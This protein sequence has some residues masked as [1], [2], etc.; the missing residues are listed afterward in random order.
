MAFGTTKSNF[1][2]AAQ[3][4]FGGF[5][6]QSSLDGDNEPSKELTESLKGLYTSGNYSD[7]AITCRG[8]S[9]QVHKAIEAS[10]GKIDLPD[11]DPEAV[12]AMISYLYLLNYD[13]KLGNA[14]QVGEGEAAE[15]ATSEEAPAGST[16]ASRTRP[17]L[18]AHAKVYILADKCLI[19]GLK[20]L[21]LRKFATSVREHIDVDDFVHAM[22]EVYNF[23][24]EN[25]KGL[26][27]V[28]VSTLC[29]RRYLLDQKEVQVVL[30]DLGAVTYDLVITMS[31]DDVCKDAIARLG[32]NHEPNITA[33]RS[34]SL[35]KHYMYTATS[36]LRSRNPNI[37]VRV[38][39][40]PSVEPVKWGWTSASA[41]RTVIALF[42][43]EG[44][45]NAM[46]F[47]IPDRMWM[48]AHGAWTPRRALEHDVG[49]N[50]YAL[51]NAVAQVALVGCR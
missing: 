26:R 25:D 7:L 11:D 5:A 22:Q 27:D 1:G 17:A 32:G 4:P 15:T 44:L 24:L 23:T 33:S 34:H 40:K 20:A 13:L 19:S 8:K 3:S 18:V 2:F 28:I 9:Y 45:C 51:I 46:V 30:K 29:K 38:V 14:S 12:D 39:N 10:E 47:D 35:K 31:D 50:T 43:R 16:R 41:P 6:D 42:E 48:L 49:C 37:L 21:A 36:L